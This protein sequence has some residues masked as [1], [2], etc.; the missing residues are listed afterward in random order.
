LPVI[1]PFRG[2]HPPPG[3]AGPNWAIGETGP[4]LSAAHL[5]SAVAHGHLVRDG[6]PALYRYEVSFG[7][8]DQRRHAT[9]FLARLALAVDEPGHSIEAAMHA[10]REGLHASGEGLGHDVEPVVFRYPDE[11]GWVDEVLSSNAF[12]EI[13]RL[14]DEDGAEHR[15][16]R[17]DRSE[18]MQEVVAQFEDKPLRLEGGA[19][20]LEHARARWLASGKGS[21]GSVLVL[22]APE[23]PEKAPW[24]AGLVMSPLDEPRPRPWQELA[25]DPGKAKWRTPPLR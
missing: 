23:G 14:T 10:S 18:G 19:E 1:A 9:G 20:Q 15:L 24:R 16:W 25:G 11:R 5:R 2:L 8:P 4:A 21:D 12:D 13:A 22:L 17:I 7:P 3:R 6:V